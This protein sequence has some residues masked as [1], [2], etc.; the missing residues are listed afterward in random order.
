[1]LAALAADKAR[2]GRVSNA[3]WPLPGCLLALLQ[4]P[5]RP[6]LMPTAPISSSSSSPSNFTK[7]TPA[8]AAAAAGT[9]AAS[10]GA[11]SMADF[12]QELSDR[13]PPAANVLKPFDDPLGLL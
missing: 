5:G 2:S 13:A 10:L 7:P 11:K 3:M 9:A 8:A 1:M 6:P 12:D 4:S